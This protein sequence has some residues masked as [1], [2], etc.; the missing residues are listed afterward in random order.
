[1]LSAVVYDWLKCQANMTH[2][3]F[4]GRPDFSVSWLSSTVGK[5]RTRNPP[6]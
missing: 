3:L 4:D 1:M 6:S 2:D 5:F